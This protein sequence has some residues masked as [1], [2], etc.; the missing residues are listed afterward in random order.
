MKGVSNMKQIKYILFSFIILFLSI[1]S[2]N[3]DCTNEELNELKKEASKIRVTYKHLGAVEVEGQVK[4]YNH[5]T[6]TFKNI[7]EDFYI[8]DIYNETIKLE[9]NQNEI[10]IKTTTGV[11]TYFV[12]SN[13]CKTVITEI[14]VKI[15][16]FNSYSLDPLCDGI[17]GDDFPLCGKYLDYEVS[18]D[19]FKRKVEDYKKTQ[20]TKK[21][22]DERIEND[23][24]LRESL[25]KILEFIINYQIY[26]IAVLS[27]LLIIL[28]I[29]TILKR[30]KKRGVLE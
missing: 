6:M 30:K 15:P 29:I 2:V 4:E 5:F 26:I 8:S 27:I 12:N 22:S 16:R 23:I 13:K 14:K 1:L 11:Y 3:A 20:E 9:E 25:N 24:S 17:D 19:T 7:D 10:T 28:I 21:N 18:Y